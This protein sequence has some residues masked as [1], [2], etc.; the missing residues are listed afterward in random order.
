MNTLSKKQASLSTRQRCEDLT[1]LNDLTLSHCN[2]MHTL[3]RSRRY[4][5]HPSDIP[6]YY[7]VV[8]QNSPHSIKQNIN[9]VSIGGVCFK[10]DSP[11]ILGDVLNL[12]IP[13]QSPAFEAEGVVEWCEK[14]KDQ[15]Y[16]GVSFKNVS[17]RFA[18]KMIEQ[19]CFIEHYRREQ[20]SKGR[21]MSSDLAAQEW[22]QQHAAKLHSF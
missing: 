16:V 1:L 6:L 12:S 22:I 9:D 17:T 3:S 5:R 15:F 11:L 14:I 19:V 10:V 8:S 4:I 18:V 20:C 7:K 2:K 21:Q 13:I